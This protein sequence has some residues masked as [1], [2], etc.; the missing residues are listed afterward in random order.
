[1]HSSLKSSDVL[2][3]TALDLDET[4][5]RD[6]SSK[7]YILGNFPEC[8]NPG[9][10]LS[11]FKADVYRKREQVTSYN[12]EKHEL[13]TKEALIHVDYSERYNNI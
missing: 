12:K 5:T 7:D 10:L 4:Y 2:P 3:P 1:M 13:K 9:L 6:S 11:D 8:L